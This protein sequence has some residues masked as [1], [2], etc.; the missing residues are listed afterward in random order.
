MTPSRA[1]RAIFEN[2]KIY[3]IFGTAPR[4]PYGTQPAVAPNSVSPIIHARNV[5]ILA[6]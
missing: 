6:C 1:A 3:S 2:F 5:K 4:S